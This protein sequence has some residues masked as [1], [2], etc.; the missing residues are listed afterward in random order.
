MNDASDKLKKA[1]YYEYLTYGFAP[2][3]I[4]IPEGWTGYKVGKSKVSQSNIGTKVDWGK[5]MEYVIEQGKKLL[6]EQDDE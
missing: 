3:K 4:P 1:L 6:E 5:H 2:P